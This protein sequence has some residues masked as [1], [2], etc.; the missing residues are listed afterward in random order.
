MTFWDMANKNLLWVLVILGLLYVFLL[1]GYFYVKA[2]KRCKQLGISDESV[3]KVVSSSITFS[4]VPSLSIIIGLFS[5]SGLLG[6]AWSWFRLSVVGAVTYE[7]MSADMAAKA[8]GVQSLGEIRDQPAMYFIAVMVVMSVGILSG[9]IGNI[10]FAKKMTTSLTAYNKK[11]GGWGALLTGSFMTTMI[12]VFLLVQLFSGLVPML[13]LFTSFG[14]ALLISTVAKKFKVT[15]L[16]EFSLAITLILGMAS[17]YL[18]HNL[19]S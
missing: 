4:I 1:S 7:L 19:L 14:I 9:N 10:F 18:W 11:H 5:L 16:S 17:G 13:T 15:W 8:L 3:K 2:K 12:V 6:R